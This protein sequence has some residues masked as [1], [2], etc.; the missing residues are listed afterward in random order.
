MSEPSDAQREAK[1]QV[2][3]VLAK[4][5]TEA[6]QKELPKEIFTPEQIREI[7]KWIKRQKDPPLDRIEAIR[8]LVELG[9]RAKT[10]G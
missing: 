10:K 3:L 6:R 2:H 9:L 8:R 5:M 4:S 7:D 1:K